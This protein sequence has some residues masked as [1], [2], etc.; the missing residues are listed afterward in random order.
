MQSC[1]KISWAE[2]S[3]MLIY[4]W[5]IESNTSNVLL[6][7][8]GWIRHISFQFENIQLKFAKKN[9]KNPTNLDKN[10]CNSGSKKLKKITLLRAFCFY[11]S[12]TQF[13]Q[14]QIWAELKKRLISERK[15]RERC[16]V[17][18]N[19]SHYLQD[20]ATRKISRLMLINCRKLNKQYCPPAE[21]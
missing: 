12:S 11:H 7:Y 8:A 15:A 13:S 6:R 17:Y 14:P 16:A 19:S 1:G 20:Q 3:E 9:F 18:E 5:Y 10:R 4:T 21:G 2:A